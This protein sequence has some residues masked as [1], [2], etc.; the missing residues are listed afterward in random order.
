MGSALCL[1]CFRPRKS[2]PGRNGASIFYLASGCDRRA[3]VVN[4]PLRVYVSHSILFVCLFGWLAA[5]PAWSCRSSCLCM[6]EA[7]MTTAS[8]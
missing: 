8:T 7:A 6:H 5:A 2:I 3:S 1:V 4:P